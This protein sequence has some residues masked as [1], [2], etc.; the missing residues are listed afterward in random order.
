MY[1]IK[2]NKI[3]FLLAAVGSMMLSLW[4][5]VRVDVVNPD[6]ICYLQSAATM[7]AGLS[8]AMHLCVQAVWPFYSMLI[9]AIAHVT[10][11]SIV[12]ATFLLD[13]VFSFISVMMFVAIVHSVTSVRRVVWLSLIVILLPH[14]FNALRTEVLRDHGFWAFYL[15]SIW[16]FLHFFRHKT[17]SNALCWAIALCV[18]TLFRIEGAVFLLL[19]PLLA[20][21]EFGI[22][23][24][25]RLIAFLKLNTVTMVCG[26]F[27]AGWVLFHPGQSLGRI[28]ELQY[29]LLHGVSGVIHTYQQAAHALGQSVLSIYSAKDASL[30]L[31]L[32]LLSWYPVSVAINLSWVYAI[33][34]VYAWYQKFLP[35]ESALRRTLWGYVAVNVIVTGLFLVQNLFLTK[36]YLIALSLTLMFWVPFALERLI[37]QWSVRKWPVIA[38]VFF[39]AFY[40]VGGIFSF[41]YSKQ[42]LR[43]AGVWLSKNTPERANIYSNN[44]QISYY[45][46]RF[47]PMLFIKAR[48]FSDVNQ[49]DHEKWR[50]YDYVVLRT[51]GHHKEVIAKITS[52]I[53]KPPIKTFMNKRGDGVVIYKISS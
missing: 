37:Q 44:L 30:V 21:T 52:D 32:M 10:H 18:A 8:T 5:A 49:I 15:I 41:G 33:L 24:K 46:N 29:Q 36:R 40:A 1:G 12:S 51:S 31:F 45:M 23:R 27:I 34:V 53:S 38:A 19:L 50:Q 3:V 4:S 9:F 42:Y 16:Y 2:Q 47:G 35:S 17:L 28:N 48:Q 7:S 11:L 26:S 20:W 25:E 13:G 39:I 43:D 6:G 14:E 22:T